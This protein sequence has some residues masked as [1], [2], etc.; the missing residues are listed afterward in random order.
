MSWL[1]LSVA[2][3]PSLRLLT[4]LP[5]KTV[6][7]PLAGPMLPHPK[8][9]CELVTRRPAVRVL[10]YRSFIQAADDACLSPMD[11]L[12]AA[13]PAFADEIIA[14]AEL[15]CAHVRFESPPIRS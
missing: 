6:R 13:Y 3:L 4:F 2:D 11:R 12:R 8:D 1:I 9:L 15:L 14:N 10:I 7:N 5:S